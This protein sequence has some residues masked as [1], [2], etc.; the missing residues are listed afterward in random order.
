MTKIFHTIYLELKLTL[1]KIKQ[2]TVVR[3]VLYFLKV[4]YT[5]YIAIAP[6]RHKHT[7]RYREKGGQ[8]FTNVTS[9]I[10]NYPVAPFYNNIADMILPHFVPQF[11]N[12]LKVK[13]LY[14]YP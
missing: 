10:T 1:T 7:I 6:V 9:N 8:S 3:F 11:S 13:I 5:L 12:Y 4:I 14:F 2:N